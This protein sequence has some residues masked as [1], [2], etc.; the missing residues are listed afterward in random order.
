MEEKGS[1]AWEVEDGAGWVYFSRPSRLNALTPGS[2]RDIWNC[3]NSLEAQSQ[4]RVVV[5]TGRGGAFCAG[6]ELKD[7]ENSTPL[8]ARRRA[9]EAQMITDRIAELSLP[10]IAAVN[11]VAMGLGLE[12]CLACDLALATPAARFAFPEVRLGMIPSGGGTQRLVRIV[13]LRRAREMIFTGRI[14]DAET[15]AEWGLVNEVVPEAELAAKVRE[16]VEKM[17]HGG[18]T[19]LYLAKRCLSRSLDL[20]IARGL[21]LELES[22]TTCFGSGDPARSLRR[23]AE[24]RGEPEGREAEA[25]KEP[26]EE[27][28]GAQ[29]AGTVTVSGGED[30]EEGT[31]E[32]DDLFE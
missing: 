27:G 31:P 3:L 18:R 25:G 4:V 23:F 26:A 32:E 28:R 2:V 13:G 30:K 20:D 7:L 11:G 6:M 10:T 24:E 16:W 12:I 15:A 9:R 22:F 1:V 14:V 8:A 5:F 21:E 19:A 17:V 29:P